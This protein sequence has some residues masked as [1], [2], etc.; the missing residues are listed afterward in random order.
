MKICI[1]CGAGGH[2]SQ[3][4]EIMDAFE[5]YDTFFVI[6]KSKVT[7]GIDLKDVKFIIHPPKPKK[8]FGIR[9]A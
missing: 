6:V 7:E 3:I 2:L 1:S 5:G 8:L 4:L 9:F